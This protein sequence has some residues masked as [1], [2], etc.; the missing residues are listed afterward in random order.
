MKESGMRSTR[1]KTKPNEIRRPKHKEGK[2]ILIR[3]KAKQNRTKAVDLTK[4]ERKLI[5]KE[6]NQN[7]IERKSFE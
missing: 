2:E 7:K 4:N 3:K 6:R 1:I 5:I